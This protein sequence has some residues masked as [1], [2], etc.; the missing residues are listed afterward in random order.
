M[1][2]WQASHRM[3]LQD[4]VVWSSPLRLTLRLSDVLMARSSVPLQQPGRGLPEPRLHHQQQQ[5]KIRS[6]KCP[7]DKTSWGLR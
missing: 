6:D 3:E 2:N 4:V 1:N 7:R 5:R